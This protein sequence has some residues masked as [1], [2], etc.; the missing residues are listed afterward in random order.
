MEFQ[1][2][3][4][5][6]SESDSHG[7]TKS[8][9]NSVSTA[10]KTELSNYTGGGKFEIYARPQSSKPTSFKLVQGEAQY[11]VRISNRVGHPDLEKSVSE[12][13]TE[14]S[15]SYN[16]IILTKLLSEDDQIL[17]MDV[18]PF[19]DGYH[20]ADLI[21]LVD[22]EVLLDTLHNLHLSLQKFPDANHVKAN[23]VDIQNR[24]H[25]IHAKYGSSLSLPDQYADLSSLDS[26]RDAGQKYFFDLTEL[27]KAQCLHGQPHAHNIL[28]DRSSKLPIFIDSETQAY[29]FSSPEFDY[30]Y[31]L[32]RL[33]LQF[34]NR[35]INEFKKYYER[36]IE[37]C[38]SEL[39]KYFLLQIDYY[40]IFSAISFIEMGYDIPKSEFIKFEKFYHMTKDILEQL[41]AAA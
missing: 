18:R 24:H 14:S 41:D 37:Y 25:S 40:N 32:Q 9:T 8:V 3:W 12:H 34:C 38:D 30:A 15:A 36:A 21:S 33:V 26:V 11:F 23:A 4:T 28:F 7:Y 20:L 16:P 27:P 35:G 5:K 6:G 1:F 13:L 31:M 10:F 17:R 22:Y 2:G 39:L 29:I 19:I